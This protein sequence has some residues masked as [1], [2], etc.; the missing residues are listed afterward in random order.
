[1]PVKSPFTAE[2]RI[3]IVK[4]FSVLK[5]STLVRR[6]YRREFLKINLKA[7]P[8]PK[9]FQ[10]VL[11][12]FEASGDVGDTKPKVKPEDCIPQAEVQSV[13]DFFKKH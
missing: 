13:A 10:R 7:V 12:K 4:Q 1:M 5:S 9:Q 6:A 8:H 11:A 3:W 2:Q